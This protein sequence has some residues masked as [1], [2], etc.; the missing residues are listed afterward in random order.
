YDMAEDII[1]CLKELGVERTCVY[2]VSQGG[3]IAQVLAIK[4]PQLVE[5]LVICSS[6][7]RE[8]EVLKKVIGRWIE[9]AS[10]GDVVGFNHQS[11][12]DVYSPAFLEGVK[13]MLPQ[14]EQM[15]TEEDCKRLLV[16]LNACIG[17][18]IYD[19]LENIDCPVLVMGDEQDK[20]LGIEGTYEIAEALGC[21]SYV[22]NGYSHAVYDE[23][24]DIKNRVKQF[25]D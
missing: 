15:G 25:L 5:K 10:A 14:L 20:V 7:C 1:R 6:A 17:L 16:E 19:Q 21:D 18:D 11:F 12:M 4:Y 23:A 3:M 22:Y 24:P 9:L 2:G 13:D 8:N